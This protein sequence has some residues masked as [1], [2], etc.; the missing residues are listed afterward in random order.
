MPTGKTVSAIV[1]KFL[2]DLYILLKVDQFERFVNQSNITDLQ[3][4][5][6]VG[7]IFN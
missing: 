7:V 5:K 1:L 4:V 3:S 6:Q 2:S